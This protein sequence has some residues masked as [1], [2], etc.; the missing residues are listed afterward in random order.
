M[1]ATDSRVSVS[2]SGRLQPADVSLCL[3]VTGEATVL[4]MGRYAEGDVWLSLRRT[5]DT[6]LYYTPSLW[7]DLYSLGI[8]GEH[9]QHLQAIDIPAE[10]GMTGTGALFAVPVSRVSRHRL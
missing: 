8:E 7:P 1:S 6:L 5:N 4:E 9:R 2:G 3:T 10:Q